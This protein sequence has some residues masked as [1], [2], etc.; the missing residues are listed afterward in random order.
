MSLSLVVVAAA[1]VLT[2]QARQIQVVQ[3]VAAAL[4]LQV[5]CPSRR[6]RK[7]Q[8]LLV[9]VDLVGLDKVLPLEEKALLEEIRLSERSQQ[10]VAAVVGVPLRVQTTWSVPTLQ[11]RGALA[12]RVEVV[13]ALRP[14][15][16]HTTGV[17]Q[18]RDLR[19]LL[20]APHMPG[21]RVTS[22]GFITAAPARV[23]ERVAQRQLL[24]AEQD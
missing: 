19:S 16:T 21:K 3:V 8:Y 4:T 9:Q 23:V 5:P 20:V 24:L 12:L 11:W 22:A 13:V 18:V 14:T 15:G 7:F 10:A 6:G 17:R 1:Q 2:V